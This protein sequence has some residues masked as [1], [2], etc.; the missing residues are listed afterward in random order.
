MH[1]A[2]R[3][4]FAGVVLLCAVDSARAQSSNPIAAIRGDRWSEAEAAAAPLADPVPAKLVRYY[5]LLAPGAA[6]A[7]EIADFI[8]SSPDWPA[9]PLLERRRQEAL[10]T[11]PDPTVVA[12]QC[13]AAPFT[14]AAALLRCADVLPG[15]RAAIFA[16][17]AWVSAISDPQSEVA[18]LSRWSSLP[19]PDDEWARYQ[20]LLWKDASAAT[21]QAARLDAK[22]RAL[23]LSG[24]DSPAV[25]LE[26]A[27]SLRQ[28]ED[29]NGAA[30][31][32]MQDA[33][34]A[35]RAAPDHLPEFWNERSLVIR[36]LLRNGD[37]ASAYALAAAH[38]QTGSEQRTDAEFLAGFIALRRLKQPNVALGHFQTL[39]NMS[40][41]AITQGRAHYWL[42][43]TAAALGQDPR[44][45]YEQAAS[46]A[47]TFYGQLAAVA[48]G[49]ET[50]A[51]S[52]RINALRDPDWNRD[53]VL[54]FT[55]HEVVRA[56]TWLVAWGDPARARPF[57]LRMDELAPN[58][59]ERALTAE[60][61]LKVGLPDMAVF[62][63]R[64]LGRDGIALPRAGWPMPY[65]PPPALDQAASLGI[66]RQE[67]S[68]DIGAV[69][70]SGARGL[71][72]LMPPTATQVARK[73]G[74][75]PAIPSLTVDAAHNMRLGTS[76]L[77]EVLDRFDG[78]LPL[79]AAAY[80][81]GPH[82]VDRW[83][84]DNGDP[85]TGQVAMIDWLELI[86]FSETRNY[87][88]RVL[89]N[90]AVYRARSGSTTPT[91]LAQWTR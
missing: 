38:G 3:F 63:A 79:A 55:G 22:Q 16:R 46:W 37:D 67:S 42:G 88:Q 74:V 24:R 58:P 72:Q 71:M 91:L 84:A 78:A 57:L 70:P 83:L 49:D 54:A 11:E 23:A 86:P 65:D 28:A 14:Q 33:P 76:Y 59:A 7:G 62:V 89:E 17:R 45:E 82:R 44:P 39:A 68:F 19:T 56:A 85:R 61:A 8:R 10:A 90:V 6:T 13:A 1:P 26:R 30:A 27:R 40:R 64:R 77:K 34:A 60:L 25:V 2:I 51:L 12:A 36:A 35:Q 29:F 20:R 9:Q 15:E 75:P 80:N 53:T 18:F 31:V 41:A 52:A 47:T 21:R 50:P 4:A 73:L 87:V 32:W 66:M 43:R 69:S 81:A 48:L 5:R